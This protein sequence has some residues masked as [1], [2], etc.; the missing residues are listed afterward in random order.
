MTAFG[1]A[2]GGIGNR[3][4]AAVS[5][6]SV[7][8]RFLE[9]MVRLPE[10]LWDFETVVRNDVSTGMTRGKVDVSIR[11]TRTSEAEG[12]ARINRKLAQS[13]VAEAR[14]LFDEF[15]LA[16]SL[17]AGDILSAPGIIEIESAEQQMEEGER[18]E[19]RSLV[20]AALRA[21]DEM[22][23]IEGAALQRDISERLEAIDRLRSEIAE[24]RPSI[25][26]EA[27]NSYRIRV[28]E[29][30]AAAGVTID[31][32]RLAQETV[33]MVEKG[34]VAEELTRLE[35]HISQ[36][37]AAVGKAEPV[38]K[39]LD[40]LTQEMTR[41]INTLGQKSRS[42]VVRSAVV[43]FRTEVERIKEQ[44]QNVE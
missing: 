9:V 42:A 30:A 13:L 3:F 10:Y 2:S 28:G 12:S 44:V 17:R 1:R 43:E 24:Q 27:L 18:E 8:H 7:N 40:F 4:Q 39:R 23:E 11:L 25:V 36:M 6:R 15:G 35:S 20:S 19:L 33:L 38:G 16:E 26:E 41:E 22:R 34:D 29:F 5:V 21:A 37:R 32:D 31:A 14:Q